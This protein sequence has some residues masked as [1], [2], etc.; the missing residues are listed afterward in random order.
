MT[1]FSDFKAV[2]QGIETLERMASST[3]EGWNKAGGILAMDLRYKGTSEEL[4]MALDGMAVGARRL[5]V[6]DFAPQR[7]DCQL[8]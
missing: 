6:T 7:V 8:N 5:S 2:S 1:S 4:A 3:K